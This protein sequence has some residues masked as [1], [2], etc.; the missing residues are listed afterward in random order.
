MGAKPLTTDGS[1]ID[2]MPTL[3]RFMNLEVPEEVTGKALF[4]I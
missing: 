3:C 1:L 2:I 4:Q